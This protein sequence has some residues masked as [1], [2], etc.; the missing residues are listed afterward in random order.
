MVTP[1]SHLFCSLFLN[2]LQVVANG[3]IFFWRWK[4][5]HCISMP[6]FLYSFTCQQT[7]RFLPYLGY[8]NRAA[9]SM[10]A[11]IL[12]RR[13]DFMSLS[14]GIYLREGL[15]GHRVVLFF[16][17]IYLF[18]GGTGDLTQE[19]FTTELYPHL[20]VLCKTGSQLLWLALNLQS[21]CPG[22]LN[23]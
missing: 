9:V 7:P 4:I 20:F 21:C 15:L 13:A 10:G 17:F 3:K 16:I 22:L 14:L 12:L 18:Q 2:V 19:P 5:L 8:V 1:W 6:R 23:C 11:R